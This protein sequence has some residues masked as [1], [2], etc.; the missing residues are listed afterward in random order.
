M[1]TFTKLAACI[2]ALMSA[3]Q[4]V[5]FILNW[6]VTVQDLAIPR[7]ISLCAFVVA[8]LMSAMLWRESRK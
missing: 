8:G 3:V 5:R 1:K 2:F 4:L 7:W 6:R